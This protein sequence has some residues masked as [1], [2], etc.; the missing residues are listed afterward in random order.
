MQ[1]ANAVLTE[2]IP[3]LI[4]RHA[5][6]STAAMVA[7][8]LP[9]LLDALLLAR[10][11]SAQASAASAGYPIL[12]MIQTIGFTLGMGAGSSI[13]RSLGR[14]DRENALRTASTAFFLALLLSGTLCAF[15]LI[16][17]AP[18]SRL[19]GADQQA[20]G[21]ASLY[22]RY[23]LLTGP[24]LCMNLVLSSLLRAQAQMRPYMVAYLAG[25][26]GG[27]LLQLLLIV[28]MNM[29]VTGSGIAML[30]R[31]SIV[32]GVLL[33]SIFRKGV[34]LR[35]R[36]GLLSLSRA[37]LSDIMRSGT[38]TLLR[39]GMTT[40]SSALITRSAAAFGITSFIGLGLSMRA[41]SIVSSAII[42]FG[43]GFQPVCGVAFGANDFKRV[44][45]AYHF[46]Q[47]FLLAALLALGAAVFAWSRQVLSLF[48]AD[49]QASSVAVFSLR[50]Q[51][52]TFFAQGAV[53]M[54]NMLVQSIGLPVRASLIA[55][56]RQGYV[57]IPLVLILPRV[58]GL[59][60]LLLSQS[61]SDILSL[62]LCIPLTR[63]VTRSLYAPRECSH[64][65]KA[66]P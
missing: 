53:V 37:M 14:R 51:S 59:P 47:R 25:G 44:Q 43:Q 9:Q 61:S 54:M 22:I 30:V 32:S 5:A 21:D 48:A 33:F 50:A 49:P 7:A 41:A 26:T 31:E 36:P 12:L 24:L 62:L 16:W 60:G 56:S 57:L 15:G 1:A 45:E 35:P 52:M 34:R 55:T 18:L 3:A 27:C 40:L 39:Q 46:C 10:C 42:G 66:S 2:K 65:Q 29:G 11:G 38:P 63:S 23:M 8:G 28:M 17:T 64:A 20:L 19:L 58:F 13:S 6:P 4:L